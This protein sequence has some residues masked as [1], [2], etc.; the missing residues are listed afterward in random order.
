MSSSLY[1]C[2]LISDGV[3]DETHWI[4]GW[5]SVEMPPA[6]AFSGGLQPASAGGLVRSRP[7]DDC[8]TEA[9]DLYLS[10]ERRQYIGHAPQLEGTSDPSRKTV[11]NKKSHQADPGGP[12]VWF[13]TLS[14]PK[15]PDGVTQGSQW[16]IGQWP[17]VGQKPA[18]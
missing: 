15:K 7:S 8:F 3:F 6:L 17:P 1:V 11:Y 12:N 10:V 5:M 2:P 4:L 18:T 16:T 13:P 9:R 14:T